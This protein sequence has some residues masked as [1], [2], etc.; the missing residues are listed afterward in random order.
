M[1]FHMDT[2]PPD[3]SQLFLAE[4]MIRHGVP[5][6]RS[7]W[8]G[9]TAPSPAYEL[10][11]VVLEFPVPDSLCQWQDACQPDL[12][13]AEEHFQER[14]SGSPMNPTPSYVRWPWHSQQEAERFI[15]DHGRFD[16][17]YPERYWPKNAGDNY[18]GYFG[19]AKDVVRLLRKDHWT[20]QAYLPVW[21]PE[22]TGAVNGQRVPCSLGY[23]FI[24]NGSQLDCSYFLRSCDLTRHYKNDVYLTGRLMQW[25]VEQVQAKDGLPYAGT[26]TMFISN[27]HLFTQDK[28]RFQ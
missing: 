26:L 1:T 13:W 7:T 2:I 25:M 3:K 5:I 15:R 8:Q 28:W 19:D 12:P 27:L 17:T 9:T 16:H 11:N 20:R 24:R 10:R 22:D 21:F 6:Q 4:H 18:Q 14:V 23:H